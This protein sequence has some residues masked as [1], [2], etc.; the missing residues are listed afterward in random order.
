MTENLL[1]YRWED[2][3]GGLFAPRSDRVPR[4]YVSEIRQRIRTELLTPRIHLLILSTGGGCKF[5]TEG[6]KISGYRSPAASKILL[7]AEWHTLN[8][9]PFVKQF[10]WNDE[11]NEQLK[12]K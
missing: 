8:Y 2:P 4:H 12:R 6:A 5:L 11:K 3:G 7:V 9:G 1:L 10:S